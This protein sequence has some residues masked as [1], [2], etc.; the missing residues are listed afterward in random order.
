MLC[1]NTFWR[2]YTWEKIHFLRGKIRFHKSLTLHIMGKDVHFRS[3]TVLHFKV[4]NLAQ[5]SPKVSAP[6]AMVSHL[7]WD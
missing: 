3:L 7:F 4:A 6:M 5:S 1:K 2:K